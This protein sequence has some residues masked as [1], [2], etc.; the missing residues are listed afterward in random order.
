MYFSIGVTENNPS[1]LWQHFTRKVS[2]WPLGWTRLITHEDSVHFVEGACP[3]HEFPWFTMGF[4]PG[5]LEWLADVRGDCFWFYFYFES[6]PLGKT[7][8]R[9]SSP[10]SRVVMKRKGLLIKL[11]IT[12]QRKKINWPFVCTWV[13]DLKNNLKRITFTYKLKCRAFWNFPFYWK[14]S[15]L[16]Y[17]Y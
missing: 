14:Q 1:A 9:K 5:L 16:N 11:S 7:P 6:S 3:R 10:G 15:K 13:C 17:I 8:T 2:G 4:F 12:S